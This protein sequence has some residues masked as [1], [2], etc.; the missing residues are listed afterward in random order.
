VA[1]YA[2]LGI[3]TWYWITV[4]ELMFKSLVYWACALG[5]LFVAFQIYTKAMAYYR[6]SRGLRYS[7][8][9][10]EVV[11]AAIAWLL[12][13]SFQNFEAWKSEG[14]FEPFI[15]AA[16]VMGQMPECFRFAVGLNMGFGPWFGENLNVMILCNF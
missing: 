9:T 13:H 3:V 5:A 4:I 16:S 1:I 7:T 15:Q 8:E 12:I 11:C 2:T 14:V 10:I 6:K